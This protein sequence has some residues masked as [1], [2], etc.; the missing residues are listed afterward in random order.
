MKLYRKYI[1][2]VPV[3]KTRRQIVVTKDGMTTFNPSE[4]MIFADGWEEYIPPVVEPT[5]YQKDPLEIAQEIV[6]DA[7]NARTDIPDAEALE[8]SVV[9][10]NW[11][12]YFGKE[13][14]A[15][16]V[17]MYDEKVWRVRQTHT[18]LEQYEPGMDTA[19]LYEVIELVAT[20][21]KDDPIAYNP[22][23]EVF[24]G[25]YYTQYGV[26][27]RCIWDSGTALTH[28]ITSLIGLY[29]EAVE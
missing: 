5:P 15:G 27:Y 20:G 1:D 16:Q 17:V 7:Y 23:M 12:R 29:F 26:T 18:V 21:E 14:K 4:E 3:I 8:R 28:D 22:P 10:Y 24:A 6:L 9:V 2:G 19:A 11:D 13:L 25:K